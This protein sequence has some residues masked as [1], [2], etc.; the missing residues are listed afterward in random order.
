MKENGMAIEGKRLAKL[1][2]ALEERGYLF[3]GHKLT[4]DK[5]GVFTAERLGTNPSPISAASP[6]ALL[7]AVDAAIERD[8][9]SKEHPT[10]VRAVAH[11]AVNSENGGNK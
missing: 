10:T 8:R 1:N 6:V 2:D 7:R 5:T 9:A 11:G 3:V 4:S